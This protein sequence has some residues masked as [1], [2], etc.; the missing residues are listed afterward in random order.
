MARGKLSKDERKY[1]TTKEVAD[2][3]GITEDFAYRLR[4][5]PGKGPRWMRIGGKVLYPKIEVDKWM[6]GALHA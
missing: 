1:L 5:Q 2:L 6:E 3:L 4:K